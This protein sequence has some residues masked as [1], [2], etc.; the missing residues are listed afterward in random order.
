MLEPEPGDGSGFAVDPA[1][2]SGVAGELGKSYDDLN[3]G[4]VDLLTTVYAGD[5]NSVFGDPDVVTAWNAFSSAYLSEFDEDIAA[6]SELITKLLTTAQR[7]AETD[8]AVTSQLNG[9]RAT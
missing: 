2:L 1:T 7:Y 6:V 5:D 3:N 4:Y 8:A 9:T